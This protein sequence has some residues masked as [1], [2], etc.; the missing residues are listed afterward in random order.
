MSV[1][2]QTDA[3][4]KEVPATVQGN[5]ELYA[6]HCYQHLPTRNIKTFDETPWRCIGLM[7]IDSK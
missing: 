6:I 5:K 3:D 7:G 1:V 2:L 4:L